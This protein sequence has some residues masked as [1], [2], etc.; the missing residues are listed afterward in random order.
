MPKAF[1]YVR[2]STAE[3]SHG[4]SLRRQTDAASRY[5]A[6][7]DLQLD[8]RLT[9]RDLGVSAFKG[10]NEAGKLGEFLEAVKSGLVP[11]GSYLLV[12]SL[13]RIS[14][15]K[16]RHAQRVLESIVDAGITLVTLQDGQE[17]TQQRLD[18]DP[19]SFLM[20]FLT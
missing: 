12:E 17:Y 8:N 10:A 20:S 7:H 4:D 11:Q 1:S 15:K 14:R 13:D 9:Y 19:M 18:D 16:A 5:A 6:L 3:Q 2:F